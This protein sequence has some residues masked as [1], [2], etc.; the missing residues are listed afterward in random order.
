[1]SN[2]LFKSVDDTKPGVAANTLDGRTAIQIN[3]PRE[4]GGEIQQETSEISKG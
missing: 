4:C 1:M 2:T 3:G